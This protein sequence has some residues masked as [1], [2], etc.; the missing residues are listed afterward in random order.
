MTIALSTVLNLREVPN[1]DTNKQLTDY[2]LKVRTLYSWCPCIGCLVYYSSSF[3]CVGFQLWW[4]NTEETV[5]EG[6]Q[7][8]GQVTVTWLAYDWFIVHT[9]I[10]VPVPT[11]NVINMLLC[12]CSFV[13]TWGEVGHPWWVYLHTHSC[14]LQ[15]WM[16]HISWIDR[17]IKH[18]LFS[19]MTEFCKHYDL[20]AHASISSLF[21]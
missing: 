4:G 18:L 9:Y 5:E 1:D 15:C 10:L 13:E 21:S 8:R 11:Y 19:V 17:M 20:F 12:C 3:L 16:L 14:R 6:H 7:P 2:V